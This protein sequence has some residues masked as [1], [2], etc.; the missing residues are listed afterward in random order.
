LPV[1][2]ADVLTNIYNALEDY[3][4]LLFFEMTT[5]LPTLLWGLD[6][7]CWNFEDEREFGLWVNRERWERLLD[8]VGFTQVRCRL[9]KSLPLKWVLSVRDPHGQTPCLWNACFPSYR[10]P[11]CITS[12]TLKLLRIF[13]DKFKR[14]LSVEGGAMQFAAGS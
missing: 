6:A 1:T 11:V 3:G 12:A 4:F 7:Q 10:S 5:V 8:E 9:L 13:V 14:V 2:C